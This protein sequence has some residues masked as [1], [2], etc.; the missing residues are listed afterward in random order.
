[1]KK[2]KLLMVGGFL[3][4]GKTSLLWELAAILNQ[5]GEKV[6]LITNDQASELVDT[7]FLETN[8]DIVEEV[9]G[10]C[11][12][13]NFN[14]FA[15]AIK[16]I[17][18]KN[19]G[20]YIIAEPV[21][22]CTDLS[23]TIMQPLKDK[24]ADS[25]DIK[26]LTVLADPVRLGEILEDHSTPAKYILYKQFEEADIILINKSDLLSKEA[27]DKLVADV[28]KEWAN[29]TVLTAS[30]KEKSGLVE[31]LDFVESFE[32]VGHKIVEVDYDIYADGEAAFGWLNATFSLTDKSDFSK[33]ADELITN[34]G[35]RFDDLKATVGHVKFL[36]ENKEKTII[37]NLV[38]NSSTKN[39]RTLDKVSEKASL[40]VNARVETSPDILENI[41]LEEVEKVFAPIGY[42]KE[43]L[44]CLIPGRPNPTFRYNKII[45]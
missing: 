9:S 24:Y 39:I 36:I 3:G 31:W 1:M 23:A 32:N 22:S 18:D 6:G 29:A 34:L 33:E 14:G 19:E 44:K 27:L 42:K 11:F 41:I 25:L 30:V 38:G 26:S 17:A 7:K 28:Q 45:K 13:C 10:S 43:A 4:A 20:G 8:Q 35:Q 40:T 2:T 15:D 16:Y 37:A 5:K 21:G 12:C